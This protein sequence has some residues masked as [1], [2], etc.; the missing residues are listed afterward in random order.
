MSGKNQD[1]QSMRTCDKITL[2]P[3][4]DE[5]KIVELEVIS[6]FVSVAYQRNRCQIKAL[7][8]GENIRI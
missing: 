6:V 4:L 5:F 7:F 3:R 1:T 8:H 2:K